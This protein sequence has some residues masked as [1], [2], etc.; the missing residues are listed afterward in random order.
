MKT[1]SELRIAAEHPAYAG[2]FPGNP[3]LPGVVLLDEAMHCVTASRCYTPERWQIRSAKF[4]RVVRP[5]DALRIEHEAAAGGTVKW[6]IRAEAAV[7]ANGTFAP[8]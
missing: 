2:H 8:A 1:V 4:L 6:V 7:V 3:I 5:G